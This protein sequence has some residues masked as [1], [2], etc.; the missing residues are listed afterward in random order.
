M[1]Q[2]HFV[3]GEKGGVGKSLVSRVLAQYCIDRSLPFIGFD[4]DKSHGALLR[5]YADYAAPTAVD[6]YASL[7]RLVEA[8]AIQPLRRVLVDLAA[9]THQFLVRWMDD[10]SLLDLAQELNFGVRYW[11][12]MDSGKDSVDL[13]AK[14]LDQFGERLK[15]VVVLNELRGDQ[16]DILHASGQLARAQAAG[17]SVMPLRRLHDQTMQKLDAH[18][19]SFWAAVNGSDAAAALDLPA[20]LSLTMMERQRV[21]AWLNR[22]YLELDRIGV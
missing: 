11:H 9:Q 14:L 7:D 22:S 2:M 16:F 5:F 3:G 21:K 10:T 20:A 1:S 19:T 8:A 12:V 15:L 18:S 13:L 6:D 17:A 4:T